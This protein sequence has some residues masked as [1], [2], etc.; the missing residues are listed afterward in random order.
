MA[1]LRSLRT[2]TVYQSVVDA[3][4]NIPGGWAAYSPQLGIDAMNLR[5]AYNSQ[6]WKK[7]SMDMKGNVDDYNSSAYGKATKAAES[8]ERLTHMSEQRY[9]GALAHIVLCHNYVEDLLDHLREAV[10]QVGSREETQTYVPEINALYNNILTLVEGFTCDNETGIYVVNQ[11][12]DRHELNQWHFQEVHL[13]M[14][15]LV[16]GSMIA[17]NRAEATE[18][19]PGTIHWHP[20]YN[21]KPILREFHMAWE[22]TGGVHVN[23]IDGKLHSCLVGEPDIMA[24]PVGA[25]HGWAFNG[26]ADQTYNL[27]YITGPVPWIAVKDVAALEGELGA[28]EINR[29]LETTETNLATVNAFG[30]SERIRD[31]Q[32]QSGNVI[33][34]VLSHDMG[35]D[36]FV[37]NLIEVDGNSSPTFSWDRERL[38]IVQ[39]GEAVIKFGER[40]REVEKEDTF[41]VPTNVPFEVEGNAVLLCIQAPPDYRL[42]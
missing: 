15:P 7:I 16:Q 2:S 9:D 26:L 30:L 31:I 20:G 5:V 18:G 32:S 4:N 6:F 36:T 33:E 42:E 22:D 23:E 39:A 14:S 41:V 35:I 37:T 3:G 34:P 1:E 19:S 40:Q 27:G 21:G 17:Y 29:L 25:R 10:A 8:L 28:D 11:H 12:Q 38:F 13:T 24:M